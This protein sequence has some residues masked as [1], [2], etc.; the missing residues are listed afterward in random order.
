ME[1][2]FDPVT[3]DLL[4]KL[5]LALVLGA[6]LGAERAWAHKVAGIRTYAMVSMGAALFV[7]IGQVVSEKF[8]GV[9]MFD[10]LRVASQIIVGIGFLG[11]GLIIFQEHKLVGLTTAAGIWVSAGIGMAAGFGL[12]KISIIATILALIIFTILWFVEQSVKKIT[13]RE[14]SQLD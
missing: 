5:V 2:F 14:G 4:K 1:N 7:I 3:L 11:A 9:T 6:L 10:P 13:D 12:Y 8:I